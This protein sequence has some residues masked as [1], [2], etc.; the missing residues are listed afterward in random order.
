MTAIIHKKNQGDLI[1]SDAK[2]DGHI[3]A[4][5]QFDSGVISSYGKKTA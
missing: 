1:L 3:D 4:K 2:V 5:Q